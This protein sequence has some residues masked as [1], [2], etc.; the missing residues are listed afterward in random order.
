MEINVTLKVLRDAKVLT[1]PVHMVVGFQRVVED[2]LKL[3][4]LV[5]LN[6]AAFIVEVSLL[7]KNHS[8]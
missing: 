4:Q 2:F 1:W 3:N 6:A 7:E 5:I 8:L